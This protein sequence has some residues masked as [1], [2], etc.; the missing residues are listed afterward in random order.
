MLEIQVLAC[1][2]AIKYLVTRLKTVIH[3]YM[4]FKLCKITYPWTWNLK[5][6]LHTKKC[7][8]KIYTI[9]QKPYLLQ[10][11]F[12]NQKCFMGLTYLWNTSLFC[13]KHIMAKLNKLA[14]VSCPWEN[15]MKLLSNLT[16]DSFNK[17]IMK[18]K[19]FIN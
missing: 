3:I 6:I 18:T 1:D 11:L 15:K 8:R 14:V 7:P 17:L 2:R 19:L 4:Y 16:K 12:K 9:C 13:H 10:K 5:G